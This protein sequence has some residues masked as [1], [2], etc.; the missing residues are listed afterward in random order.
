MYSWC[1]RQRET[2]AYYQSLENTMAKSLIMKTRFND[3][4]GMPNQVRHVA[5]GSG[6]S[7]ASKVV[8]KRKP[9]TFNI[10]AWNVRTMQRDGKLENV[11]EE[12]KINAISV[13][14][15]SETR[16]KGSG[17]FRN[18]GHR[19]IYSGG[20]KKER[21]VAIILNQDQA[22]KVVKIQQVNDRILLV[23]LQAEPMDIVIIQVY[24]PTSQHEDKEIEDM[25]EHI[26][27]LM[28][29]VKGSD[30]AV[31]MGDWNAVVGEG[32][33]GNEVGAYGLGKR[34]RRGE[35]LIEFCERRKL[36]VTNTWYKQEKRRYT[37]KQPGDKKR[38]QLDYILVRQ[39]YRNSV[40]K[41]CSYPGADA[42]TDH[43]LVL[44]KTKLKLKKMKM[45]KSQKKWNIKKLKEKEREFNSDILMRLQSTNGQSVDSKWNDL[46]ESMLQSA[47][48][49]VG[50][51]EISKIKKPWVTEDMVKK[52][53]ER[54]KWKNVNTE[55]GKKE[56]RKLNNELRRE[57]E[58]ARE[59]WWQNTCQ[60]IEELDRKGQS[61]L[62][63]EKIRSTVGD[64]RS[65]ETNIMVNDRHGKLLTDP[66]SIRHRWKTYIE[67]LYNKNEK[68][69]P[70]ELHIEEES[71]VAEDDKG[72][73]I[74]L[75]EIDE[76][77]KHMKN[78][79]AEGVDK[80]PAE[81]LK[82]LDGR[83]RK[84]LVD[85]CT[86]MYEDG[87]WPEDFR[88]S[89]VIP[90]KKKRNAIECQDFRTISLISHAAKIMLRILTRRLEGKANEYIGRN[91]FGFRRGCGTR[92]AIGVLRT[93]CER[94]IEFNNEIYICFVDF[95]KAFDRV[96]WRLL[97]DTLKK[98]GVDWRDRR[99]IR[100]LYLNQ[101]AMIRIQGINSKPAT[102]GQGVRQG[103]LLS[104][105]LF[106]IYSERMMRDALDQTTDGI[107]VG[108]EIIM[109]IRFADDQA[110]I[111]DTE[112]G[113][114]RI[115]NH[116]DQKSKEFNMAINMK[117]TKVMKVSRS[118]ERDI[119]ISLNGMKIE[120]V[121]KFQYLGSIISSDGRSQDE[122]KARL[123]MARTAFTKRRDLLS[124]GF[125]NR[126][127]NRII[128]TI[129]WSV[130][131]YASETWTMSE[132][133]I[134]KIEAF[135]MWIWRRSEKINWKD[136]VTNEEV[137]RRVGE[138]RHMME[139]IIRRK[140]TWIGHVL[141][142]NGLLK[143]VIEGRMVGKRPQGRPRK[144]MLD[145][146]KKGGYKEMK[147]LTQKREEWRR[148]MP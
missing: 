125:N 37:W 81:F 69:T 63:Y 72:P 118:G 13:L 2:T 95:E 22:E 144:T 32:R 23:K 132:E 20:S 76:A 61:D 142:G 96:N 39:R 92:E 21:G 60:T 12:M 128:K 47:M 139:T 8:I 121:K 109:D 1:G 4:N 134:K 145:N 57:T 55:A 117:K 42:D 44:M 73:E 68:P 113:L 106:S 101:S 77:I 7:K 148:W 33:S 41:A 49:H 131:L 138:K 116:L 30:Y 94:N 10:A 99:M 74:L 108:G 56:Y 98:I 64:R 75:S 65:K 136:K 15:L 80:I 28:D 79:K 89:I 83:A 78:K 26:E 111:A 102:I 31:I 104:P 140:K 146:I 40:K 135:E 52:M 51:N 3:V 86:R 123:S 67:E 25:Y 43:N 62:M 19:I 126:V 85:L 93:L 58:K 29:Q 38:F 147:D 17:D 137:L 71:M 48:K 53:K 141:R 105:L 36:I 130:A 18:N 114:Q 9:C 129:I 5:S 14:G 35:Q 100:Q 6:G 84:E 54:R 115:M 34:N 97:M 88:K 27:E 46:K 127:K 87:E 107:K 103:C 59:K 124:K 66:E 119:N 122:I 90:I 82:A 45:K 133:D 11:L 24:M 110:M 70:D 143:T 16:W 112:A 50:Y 91:Q 120:Q